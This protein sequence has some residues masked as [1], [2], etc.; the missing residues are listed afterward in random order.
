[1]AGRYRGETGY[2]DQ[3]EAQQ[4]KESTFHVILMSTKKLATSPAQQQ[5]PLKPVT[6][7]YQLE[8]IICN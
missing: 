3:P 2:W 4:G 6:H 8:I 7:S 1:M 5:L